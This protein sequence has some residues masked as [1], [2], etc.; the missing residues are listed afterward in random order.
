ME[1]CSFFS[2]VERLA[3]RVAKELWDPLAAPNKVCIAFC[4]PLKYT[5]FWKF[6]DPFSWDRQWTS[7][8]KQN[9]EASLPLALEGRKRTNGIVQGL[10]CPKWGLK[11][12]WSK[13]PD[14]YLTHN[15]KIQR[16][17]WNVPFHDSWFMV[18][19]GPV[20]PNFQALNRYSASRTSS[21]FFIL[22]SFD[23]ED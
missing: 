20:F 3:K 2:I 5:T 7:I 18:A 15:F 12:C 17:K 23:V 19:R 16:F 9:H 22:A 10:R 14:K 13:H 11:F 1:D 8:S 6:Q 4:Y 21:M